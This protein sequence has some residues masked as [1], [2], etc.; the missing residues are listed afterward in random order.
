MA[1]ADRSGSNWT[2]AQAYTLAVFCLALGVALG[3]LFHGSAGQEGTS[4][5]TSSAAPAV[6]VP[7]NLGAAPSGQMPPV[8][9]QQMIAQASAPLLERLKQ[10]PR[11]YEAL[12]QVGNLNYDGQQYTEAISYYERALKIRPE[13]PDVRTDMGT[14]YWYLGN[15]DRALEEFSKSL[16][17]QPDHPGTLFN[18]GV[19]RWQGKSDSVGAVKAWEELLQKNPNYPQKQQVLDFIAKARQHAGRG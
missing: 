2:S 8:Q 19:V 12:V 14:A 3:Y 11:D 5:R 18:L 4:T 17:Y 16:K 10:N 1:K 6:S 15:A 7:P 13:N 9:K